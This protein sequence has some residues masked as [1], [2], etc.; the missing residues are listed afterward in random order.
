MLIELLRVVCIVVGYKILY[1]IICYVEH[2]RIKHVMF[3]IFYTTYNVCTTE[4]QP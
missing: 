4:T 2:N 1:A 3:L